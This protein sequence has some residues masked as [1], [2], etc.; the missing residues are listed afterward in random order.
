MTRVA[1]QRCWNHEAREAAAR[2]PECA[3]FF[4]RECVTEFD[5]RILCSGCLQRLVQPA[6]KKSGSIFAATLGFGGAAV[7]LLT[8]WICFYLAGRV[9]V[10]IPS[11][12]HGEALW[13]KVV[14]ASSAA[15]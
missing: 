1:F 8:A 10:S 4:C 14:T 9:L 11:E 3:R 13:E 5:D 2:C 6:K 12:F 7:G 15:D